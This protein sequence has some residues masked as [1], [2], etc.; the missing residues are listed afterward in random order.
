MNIAEN[1]LPNGQPTFTR[2][3]A[4]HRHTDHVAPLDAALIRLLTKSRESFLRYLQNRLGDRD[5]AEDVLQDF[6]IRVIRKAGQI[7]D[8][9]AAEGWLRIVLKSTLMDHFRSR[10][11]QR[12]AHQKM[13]AEWSVTSEQLEPPIYDGLAIENDDCTC[14]YGLLPKLKPE[15]AD[16]I[17][18]V[19]LAER[20]PS[21]AAH[22]LGIA[23]GTMRVRLHRAR[24]ALR[25]E[26]EQSCGG[27]R[28]HGCSA[29]SEHPG[30]SAGQE[31][32]GGCRTND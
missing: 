18:R 28:E 1:H 2:A 8:G 24:I 22:D 19:D 32:F 3:S 30:H 7:R 15:Y 10:S 26:L 13:V 12:Q 16:A 4:A 9:N 31:Q 14:F 17:A 20:T 5:E 29:P 21:D 25:K 23:A 11:S 6:C 27:C